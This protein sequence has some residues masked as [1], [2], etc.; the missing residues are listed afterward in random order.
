MP[1]RPYQSSLVYEI[2]KLFANGHKRLMLQLPTGGGKTQIASD[3]VARA[4]ARRIL[5]IVPSDEILDQTSRTLDRSK[6]PHATLTAGRKLS[7]AGVSC[8][9]AM[10][11]TLTRRLGTPMFDGWTP[12][13]IFCDEAHKLIEQHR[14]VLEHWKCPV[15][16]LSATPVR[17]DGKPLN[18][19]WPVLVC[20]PSIKTLQ[21]QG[22]LVPCR[23]VNAYMPNLSAVRK[24]GADYDQ[25]QLDRAYSDARVIE[26]APDWWL[27][28]AKGKRTI[29]F[30]SGIQSSMRLVAAYR[31]KGIRAEHVD[32]TTPSTQ[33]EAALDRLRRHQIDVLF[34]CSLFVEGLDLIEV[35]CVQLLTATASLSRFMQQVG[36]GLRPARGKRELLLLDHGG[37]SA[38]HDRVDAD[39]D[40]Y[41]GGM[42]V[43]SQK[44]TCL[45]CGT[46]IE[47]ERNLCPACF[48]T[49][50]PTATRNS[51]QEARTEKAQSKATPPRPC[52]PWAAAVSAY[53]DAH[54]R[55]RHAE[56]LPLSETE[57]YCRR[58][59]RQMAA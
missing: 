47:A 49:P 53:W 37:N 57:R 54:E 31:A 36:R 11:Q 18:E 46:L 3:L 32:G 33:R 6:I 22:F 43:E 56:G 30:T 13:L 52:P 9:L 58:L 25:E 38:R 8:L 39:R 5:Y 21:R 24:K 17:L 14:R 35:E 59:L 44:K 23:T 27:K 40:W 10:S 15:I 26:A 55:Q 34:N 45:S 50:E 12:D 1:A 4:R 28:F 19:L 29:A 48:R 42:S 20:G 51:M 41:R 7:M 2:A 16:G